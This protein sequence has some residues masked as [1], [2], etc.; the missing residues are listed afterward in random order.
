MDFYDDILIIFSDIPLHIFL[1]I[2][3]IVYSGSKWP[4]NSNNQIF[5]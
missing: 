4:E 1:K 2:L 3:D 5:P